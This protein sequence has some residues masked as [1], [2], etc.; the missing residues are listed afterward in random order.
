MSGACG[1]I[2]LLV[3]HKLFNE[4]SIRWLLTGSYLKCTCTNVHVHGCTKIYVTCSDTYDTE[5]KILILYSTV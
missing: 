5:Y 3:R 4:L 1:L 2:E